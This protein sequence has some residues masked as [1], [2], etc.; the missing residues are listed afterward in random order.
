MIF[1]E[2]CIFVFLFIVIYLHQSKSTNSQ[3]VNR[4]LFL[5]NHPYSC[6]TNEFYN[7]DYFMC[8]QCESKEYL[9]PSFDKLTCDCKKNTTKLA[10]YDSSKN[11][12]I[13]LEPCKNKKNFK[14]PNTTMLSYP[15]NPCTFKFINYTSGDQNGTTKSIRITNSHLHENDCICDLKYN[16][17]YVDF[18][19]WKPLLK[20]Y[21][22]H[23]AFWK[24]GRF[25]VD[26]KFIAFFC[27]SLQNM[28]ACNNLA[29]L[30][31]QS[32]FDTDK[33]SPCSVFLL[34]QAS[35][36][37]LYTSMGEKLGGL[38]PFLFYKK[39]KDTVQEIEEK[40]QISDD[41]LKLFSTVYSMDGQLIR[42]E[43]LQ[44]NRINHCGHDLYEM[45]GDLQF[46][47]NDRI[48]CFL[49]LETIIDMASTYANKYFFS[50]FLNHTREESN[51][52]L[53]QIPV[54][55]Q[56]A[57]EG[58]NELNSAEWQLVKRFQIIE[59]QDIFFNTANQQILVYEDSYKLRLFK[60]IKVLRKFEFRCTVTED[61]KN[62]IP[63]IVLDYHTI[64]LS[65]NNSL[66]EKYKFEFLVKFEKDTG[67]GI[68]YE[69]VLPIFIAIS[70]LFAVFRA[71]IFK[72]RRNLECSEMVVFVQALYNFV[73]NVGN[74]L[75]A[76]VIID[77]FYSVTTFLIGNHE[78]LMAVENNHVFEFCI[79]C[80]LILKAFYFFINFW[81][82]SQIDIFFVDWERPKSSD[83][84]LHLKNN[85]D[86]SSQCSSIRTFTEN[87]VSAWRIFFLANEWI[88]LSCK[89]KTS[90]FVQG[91]VSLII[92]WII[93]TCLPS[94]YSNS[95]FKIFTCA[96]VYSSVQLIQYLCR[97]FIL[98]KVIGNPLKKFLDIC[99]L[100]NVSIFTL[101]DCS[102]GFYIH[103]R[104]PHGFSDTD[105]SSM[106]FQLQRES[107]NMCGKKGLLSDSDFQTYIVLPPLNLRKHI[108]KLLP[109][110]QKSVNLSQSH[111]Q[112]DHG[113]ASMN[114]EGVLERTTTTYNR[115][116]RFFCAFIDHAIKDMDYIIKEK[117]FA[118][119]MLSCEFESFV[120]EQKGT[121][122]IDNSLT[123]SSLFLYGNQ[124][125][126]F[127][128]ELLI[129]L[130]MNLLTNNYTISIIVVCILNKL[131]QKLFRFW[132]KN[133]ISIKTLIDK[134]FLM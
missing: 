17:L 124:M 9:T 44:L 100:A 6:K 93:N 105:M 106:I 20:N 89:Q 113:F 72:C 8:V 114:A 21:L 112:K 23:N 117:T 47:K 129:F 2:K 70:L 60:S 15:E 96:V 82:I 94:F 69:I 28:T 80:A 73:S 110:K 123:F 88:D 128:M 76:V 104:S 24:R 122:Y 133:N 118:E 103:G 56:N 92:F 85:L 22:H 51:R 131:F 12:P 90:F 10:I 53:Q 77:A 68:L 39:G 127:I 16:Y 45:H 107:Q 61:N 37:A 27:Q 11:Q 126:I 25:Y 81:R 102:Y 33:N 130:T 57:F 108:E 46:F 50:I 109:S 34:G 115:V 1:Q 36:A 99:T 71:Y 64:D 63:L 75:L 120:A 91:F 18:C 13:C 111:L 95:T 119:Q 31:V 121:F 67:S 14:C 43:D 41:K 52:Y 125:E 87:N 97:S 101:M 66:S 58:N 19:V 62:T 35:D 79:Y 86:T 5:Y 84:S 7:L 40:I 55:I 32:F 38:R 83:V 4:T 54:L 26:L 98:Y 78:L 30:C 132:V 3:N 48:S 29:N 42:W 65:L 59:A 134:R 116:N 49:T 74:S